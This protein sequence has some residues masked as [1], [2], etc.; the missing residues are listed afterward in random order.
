MLSFAT[1]SINDVGLG[2]SQKGHT[3]R[4]WRALNRSCLSL[5]V[6][7]RG[8]GDDAGAKGADSG[9]SFGGRRSSGALGLATSSL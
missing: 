5:F 6:S 8:A 2:S 9:A 1:A 7:A 4:A 3:A